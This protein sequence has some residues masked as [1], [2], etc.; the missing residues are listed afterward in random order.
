MVKIENESDN[1]VQP[2]FYSP[3]M[4]SNMDRGDLNLNGVFTKFDLIVKQMNH[5]SQNQDKIFV[6]LFLLFFYKIHYL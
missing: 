1:S 5:F 2:S 3:M 4:G 6:C